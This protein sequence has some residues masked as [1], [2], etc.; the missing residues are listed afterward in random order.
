MTTIQFFMIVLFLILV[1]V[2]FP[3][4]TIVSINT[5]FLTNI[6]IN[7]STWLATFWL[8][9]MFSSSAISRAAKK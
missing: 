4:A 3:I 5:L 7:I 8:S 1:I 6:P 2:L 9:A